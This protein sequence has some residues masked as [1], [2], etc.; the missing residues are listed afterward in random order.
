MSKYLRV[1]DM[2]KDQLNQCREEKETLSAPEAVARMLDGVTPG[3]WRNFM[4]DICADDDELVLAALGRSCNARSSEY[5]TLRPKSAEFQA[6]ARFIAWA[7]EAV[8]ALA[9]R[10]AEL[11]DNL[12]GVCKR[13][14]EMI[15]RY[16]A[17]LDTAEAQLA[18]R[19]AENAELRGALMDIA[20]PKR[21]P[22]HGDPVV[23]RDRA[24]AALQGETT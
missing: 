2:L 18:A 20:D 21:F 16:D 6:N 7:R 8:P 24:R 12:V 23:L 3:P 19:D 1:E 11:E 17:K 10:V 22:S 9:A 4:G 15:H 13:E 14:A 5:R